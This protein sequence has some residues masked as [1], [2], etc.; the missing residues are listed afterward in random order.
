MLMVNQIITYGG[1]V[2]ME[3][4]QHLIDS[5]QAAQFKP[6]LKK[7]HTADRQQAFG[8]VVSKRPQARAMSSG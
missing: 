5:V 2:R 7:R 3:I 4:D 6:E 8:S 1:G